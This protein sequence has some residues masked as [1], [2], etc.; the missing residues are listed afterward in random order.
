MTTLSRL[1]KVIKG[2][3]PP[4]GWI[5]RAFAALANSAAHNELPEVSGSDNGKVLM[6]Q[7]GEWDTG[8]IP[9]E[10]PSVSASDNGKG[11]VVTNGEWGKGDLPEGV[12]SYTLS[13]EN[14]VLTV[15][16]DEGHIV[17]VNIINLQNVELND[18][19]R[20]RLATDS[21][22]FSSLV[23]D[24]T[25]TLMVDNTP[26]NCKVI[27]GAIWSTDG[28]NNYVSNTGI[29]NFKSIIGYASKTVAMSCSK[30][31]TQ[32]EP[33][34][35]WKEA[36]GGNDIIFD[37]TFG[38]DVSE[39]VTVNKTVQEIVAAITAG[40]ICRGILPTADNGYAYFTLTYYL[41]SPSVELK[42]TQSIDNYVSQFIYRL[43]EWIYTE[44]SLVI[45][46]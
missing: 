31:M 25:L 33:V 4:I 39:N 43:N 42:F 7:E 20:G 21:W 30:S 9:N 35:E 37:I 17:S 24:E 29:V 8:S 23:E 3:T 15:G 19:G 28:E 2:Y 10:L 45:D 36:G 44:T 32:Y 22:D 5:E 16:K 18:T 11:L 38:F 41:P 12:P 26:I 14:K 1:A 27:S 6:V 13:D 34:L 40:K 46:E